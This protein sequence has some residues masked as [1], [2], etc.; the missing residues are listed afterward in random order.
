MKLLKIINEMK[1]KIFPTEESQQKKGK[2]QEI[3]VG[4][5]QAESEG[6]LGPTYPHV[7]L[8]HSRGQLL[9]EKTVSQVT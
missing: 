9:S 7:A 2:D 6:T 4:A 8:T 1:E 5:T 3:L